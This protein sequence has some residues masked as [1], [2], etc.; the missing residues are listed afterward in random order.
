MNHRVM[1]DTPSDYGRDV[2]DRSW[3]VYGCLTVQLSQRIFYTAMTEIR[4]IVEPDSIGNNIWWKA[5]A[6]VCIHWK[7]IPTLAKSTWRHP[8]V[9]IVYTQRNIGSRHC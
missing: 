5:V 6:L 2:I 1:E 3:R 4:S 9:S 8:L 7:I